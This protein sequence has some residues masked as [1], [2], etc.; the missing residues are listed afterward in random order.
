MLGR[1]EERRLQAYWKMKDSD[2]GEEAGGW[3]EPGRDDRQR[4]TSAEQK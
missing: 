4:R 1:W 2:E 3:A